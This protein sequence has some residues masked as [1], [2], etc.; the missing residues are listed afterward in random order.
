M[1]FQD[2]NQ[3]G[4]W[5][6]RGDGSTWHKWQMTAVVSDTAAPPKPTLA[7][8]SLSRMIAATVLQMWK[9][10]GVCDSE[11]GRRL[12]FARHCRRTSDGRC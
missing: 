6:A 11:R 12:T 3:E 7:T 10:E 4:W 8:L 1:V 5:W 9:D 2:K